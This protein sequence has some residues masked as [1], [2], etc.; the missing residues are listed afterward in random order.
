M[1]RQKMAPAAESSIIIILIIIL[2]TLEALV[3]GVTQSNTTQVQ[4]NCKLTIGVYIIS[5]TEFKINPLILLLK[6]PISNDC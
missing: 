3:H 5:V 6:L 4:I 1:S 2:I